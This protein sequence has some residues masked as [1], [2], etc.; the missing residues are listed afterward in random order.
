MSNFDR[1]RESNKKNVE[2]SKLSSMK[3]LWSASLI[4][5][6]IL[7]G[8]NYS[9]AKVLT[10][11]TSQKQAIETLKSQWKLLPN[12][13]TDYMHYGIRYWFTTGNFVYNSY[14]YADNRQR[15]ETD[16]L[17]NIDGKNIEI[18][19]DIDS[20]MFLNETV[21]KANLSKIVPIIIDNQIDTVRASR[22]EYVNV[23]R[24][25]SKDFTGLWL[26]VS[27]PEHTHMGMMADVMVAKQDNYTEEDYAKNNYSSLSNGEDVWVRPGKV[28]LYCK[29]PAAWWESQVYKAFSDIYNEAKVNPDKK[30]ILSCSRT[31]WIDAAMTELYNKLGAMS[32]VIIFTG[33]D[34]PQYESWVTYAKHPATVAVWLVQAP[35]MTVVDPET[36]KL[37]F[38]GAEKDR[39]VPTPGIGQTGKMDGEAF[40][41]LWEW[42][43]S[44]STV[45]M[46]G[47]AANLRAQ[48]P[49]WTKDEIISMLKRDVYKSSEYTYDAN[50]FNEWI[51]Y[52]V[53]QPS[54]TMKENIFPEI[55]TQFTSKDG[56]Y[57]F[58]VSNF[59][60]EYTIVGD[61][62]SKDTKWYFVDLATIG[63]GKHKITFVG[64]C[65]YKDGKTYDFPI[66]R[67][68]TVV[69]PEK[70]ILSWVSSHWKWLD[71]SQQK[72]YFETLKWQITNYKA[73]L[74]VNL[75]FPND[76]VISNVSVDAQWNFNLSNTSAY[77]LN[78]NFAD[79]SI[80]MTVELADADWNK[81]TSEIVL[82]SDLLVVPEK[83]VITGISGNRKWINQD[84][85]QQKVYF[86][87]LKWQITNYKAWLTVNLKFNNS[88][89]IE[90]VTVDSQGK[91]NLTNEINHPISYKIW[92]SDIKLTV[93]L[94]NAQWDKMSTDIVLTADLVT[95]TGDINLDWWFS[96][97]KIYPNPVRDILNI[98]LPFWF[99]NVNLKIFNSVG[100]LYS[101]SNLSSDNNQVDVS[102][103]KAWVY[104][105]TIT[106]DK[107][108]K[109][110]EKIIKQ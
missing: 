73:W 30:Y 86:D 49:N 48:N 1:S 34:T 23:D 51:G 38:A 17:K 58:T 3:S 69:W 18:D 31:W 101:A 110:T 102:S 4:A 46:S 87:V 67:E 109:K 100:Q 61:G 15:Y 28:R 105:V 79:W 40:C 85:S 72:V 27:Q 81:S 91:F 90:N 78:Y 53:V 42:T 89:I 8:T 56:K 95:D 77:P 94:V 12:V 26:F 75:K 97:T 59:P 44:Q 35:G 33:R 103:L 7:S 19:N 63:S 68:I 45:F 83:P 57:Y 29:A 43:T 2:K 106:D 65:L 21:Y 104:F 60:A 39:V 108:N 37:S 71:A 66:S 70:P 5:A 14:P 64:K 92:D 62:V 9:D 74:K 55:K 107:W 76:V 52:G 11:S 13:P 10:W 41:A 80:K 99:D 6:M 54:K 98:N 47:I 22:W 88:T 16:N 93:E 36:Q 82:N 50:W 32:N 25:N 20:C 96:S 84:P 24:A